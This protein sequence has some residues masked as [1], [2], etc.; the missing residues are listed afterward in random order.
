VKQEKGRAGRRSTAN[1]ATDWYLLCISLESIVILL[2]RLWDTLVKEDLYFESQEKDMRAAMKLFV[3][4]THCLQASLEK[5]LSNPYFETGEP[6]EA[7]GDAC[8]CIS[9]LVS[10]S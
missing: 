1:S 4:P 7:C 9:L 5:Q 2:K 6:P 10:Q 3:L 8:A